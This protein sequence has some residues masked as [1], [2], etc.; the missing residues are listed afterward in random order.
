MAALR[1]GDWSGKV[2]VVR[3][4]DLGTQWTY[5]D[6]IEVVEGAGSSSTA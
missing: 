2:R 4:N 1:E 6:V 5:R 3:V